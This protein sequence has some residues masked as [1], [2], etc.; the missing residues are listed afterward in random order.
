MKK[1]IT[2]YSILFML[3]LILQKGAGFLIKI[4]M[5]NSITPLEYG[6][7]TLVAITIPSMLGIVTNLNFYEM[8]SHSEQ[9]KKFFGFTIVSSI[10][11]VVIL[12][13]LLFI[14]SDAFFSYLNLPREQSGVYLTAIII[15][16]L[17]VS[18]MVDFQG[19]FTGMKFYSA[20]GIIS[21]LPSITRLIVVFILRWINVTSVAIYILVFALSNVIPLLFI[22]TSKYTPSLL[23]SITTV[24]VPSMKMFGFGTGVFLAANFT[25][26]GQVFIRIVISHELGV[27]WQGLYDVSQ[28][29]VTSML[30][31][32][33][34][35]GFITVPEATSSDKRT[36][37]EDE[38]LGGVARVFFALVLFFALILLF[39]ARFLVI[40]IFSAAYAPAAEYV[41]ILALGNI[42]LFIQ[43][44]LSQVNLSWAKRG[45]EYIIFTVI[46]LCLIPT[47]PF[48]TSFLIAFFKNAGY[49][50]GF[51]GAYISFTLLLIV[52]TVLTIFGCKDLAPVRILLKRIDRLALSLAI[53][54]LLVFYLQLSPVLEILLFSVLFGILVF[55]TGYLKK[56][57][58]LTMFRGT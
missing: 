49:G 3:F 16:M 38:G 44:F 35:M 52:L 9:G 32:I 34:T 33:G 18:I 20:P 13:L 7:I 37:K 30:F 10:A 6:I 57:L 28:T 14:F 43:V 27:D 11:L 48:L 2:F 31:A 50:N 53:P 12:S 47:I 1:T 5:A 25:M 51:I 40:A 8:L 17:C 15:S 26:F 58:I 36:L 39:Y 56:E 45:R 19:V 22:A 55:A 4:V 42:F 46:P 21:A 29:L 24:Q 23:R 54:A 41:Y